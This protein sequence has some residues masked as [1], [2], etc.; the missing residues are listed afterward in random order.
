MPGNQIGVRH[1]NYEIPSELEGD[2]KKCE[3][4][5][6]KAA[7]AV[8]EGDLVK[9]IDLLKINLEWCKSHL[10]TDPIH[11]MTLW[12]LAELG[13]RLISVG[14]FNEAIIYV[15]EAYDI[16]EAIDPEGEDT[17]KILAHYARALIGDKHLDLAAGQYETLWGNYQKARG[18]K[19]E[20][21][22]VTGRQAARC[23][24]HAAVVE[25][26]TEAEKPKFLKKAQEIYKYVLATWELKEPAGSINVIET[27]ADLAINY[28]TL[29]EYPTA[30]SMFQQC[31]AGLAV[32]QAKKGQQPKNQE[33]ENLCRVWLNTVQAQLKAEQGRKEEEAKRA[34]E[35]KKAEDE[36]KEKRGQQNMRR[37]REIRD[38][39]VEMKRKEELKRQEELKKQ[40][41]AKQQDEAKAKEKQRAETGNVGKTTGEVAHKAEPHTNEKSLGTTQSSQPPDTGGDGPVKVSAPGRRRL[42]T[43]GLAPADPKEPAATSPTCLG[44][45]LAQQIGSRVR[46]SKSCENISSG[47]RPSRNEERVPKRSASAQPR[48]GEEN[49]STNMVFSTSTKTP[50]I[51]INQTPV[52]TFSR[53]AQPVPIQG[54]PSQGRQEKTLSSSAPDKQSLISQDTPHAGRPSASARSLA[55]QKPRARSS[56]TSRSGGPES[57]SLKEPGDKRHRKSRSI[58]PTESKARDLGIKSAPGEHVLGE[59][60]SEKLEEP[61]PKPVSVRPRIQQ[62]QNVEI[63]FADIER[64]NEEI[65]KPYRRQAGKRVKVGILDTGIDMKN[66][67]F[68]EEEVQ[69]RIKK[70][71]DFCDPN[72]KG[73]GRDKCGH[74]THCVALINRI[75]PAADIYV[76]RVALDFDS[77]LDEKVVAKAISVAL[78]PKGPG[79]ASKNWDVDILSLSLGFQHFSEA[80]EAALQ[81]SVRKGKIILAAA[82]NNGTL[83][84]MAY[85][86]WDSN[87]IPINSANGRGRPSDF[88]PPAA[89]GKTLTILGE[90]VPSAWI[91]TTTTTIAT[92][93]MTGPGGAGA[94]ELAAAEVLDLAPTRRM[95]GTSVATPIAAGIVALLLELAMI[96]VPDDRVTQATLCDVL[97]HLRRQAGLNELLMRRAAGTGDFLNIV[98]MDLL[99]PILTVG[100]NA[101]VIKGILARKFRFEQLV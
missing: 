7:T 27:R 78:G 3:N 74:G 79:D 40:E 90:N 1:L 58:P 22:L 6:W 26:A 99:N 8:R 13:I 33:V 42:K 88:N 89:P 97:P 53:M 86:A 94:L 49:G 31:L 87:V 93:N 21:T 43:P 24:F 71:F 19:D 48:D 77:G 62:T 55:I 17:L 34:E 98:P 100:E 81:T 5:R 50:V 15:G 4:R 46:Q 82:S 41:E 65:F 96:E 61:T 76:G 18:V 64:I 56:S 66:T 68:K 32:L 28:A 59:K 70:R 35:A 91:T 63:W 20:E 39:Q 75:A 83:R 80:I 95:S 67:A 23:W 45:D 84:A 51:T 11:P 73:T 52:T 101:A 29:K 36:A 44:N 2:Y 54:G 14:R 69:Q 60:L 37:I 10:S 92:T 25:T 72:G 9:A 30:E 12:H 47:D 57:G 38:M 16:R 85:P